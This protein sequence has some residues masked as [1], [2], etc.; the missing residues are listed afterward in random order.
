MPKPDAGP[1]N[2]A[3]HSDPVPHHPESPAAVSPTINADVTMSEPAAS[4]KSPG[5][6]DLWSRISGPDDR[7]DSI[8]D[9]D[10]IKAKFLV[11]YASGDT[12]QGSGGWLERLSDEDDDRARVDEADDAW[13]MTGV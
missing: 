11:N 9:S 10:T 1:P 6:K 4:T 3:R 12:Y 7:D 2:L 8:S 5:F 13:P